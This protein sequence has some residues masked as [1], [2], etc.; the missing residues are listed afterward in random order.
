MR[1]SGRVALV[2]GCVVAVAGV[3]GFVALPASAGV[4]PIANPGFESG[5]AG[6]SCSGVA[7]AAA[8]AHSGG[9]ALHATPTGSDDA[10]CTQTVA[11]APGTSYTLTAWVN[12]SYV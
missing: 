2:V 11:V 1:R 10:Q 6:W 3:I 7:T 9:L 12:G 8:G 4:N 5:L